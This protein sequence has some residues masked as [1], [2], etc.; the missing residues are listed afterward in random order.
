MAKKRINIR[1]ALIRVYMADQLVFRSSI[2]INAPA[3]K[4]WAILI[5]PKMTKKFMFGAEAISD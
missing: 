1:T 3:S 5:N 2:R 4:V